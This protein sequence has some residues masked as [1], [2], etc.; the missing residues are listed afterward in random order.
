MLYISALRHFEPTFQVHFPLP[1]HLYVPA[2][3]LLAASDIKRAKTTLT[4]QWKQVQKNA[5]KCKKCKKWLK[6]KSAK[7]S[8]KCICT[9]PPPAS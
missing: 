2:H 1:H 7:N 6:V 8:K 3:Q 4:G 9:P 5:K